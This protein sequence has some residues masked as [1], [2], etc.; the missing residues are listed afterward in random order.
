MKVHVDMDLCQ[1]YG[2]CVFAAPDVFQLDD[3]G[4]LMYEPHPDESTQGAVSEAVEVCPMQAIVLKEK[5][6][7]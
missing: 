6:Q 7:S 1:N 5:V 3:N 4:Q 2:Q